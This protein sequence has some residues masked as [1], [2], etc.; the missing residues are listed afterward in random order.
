MSETQLTVWLI[1]HAKSSWAD[2]GT[3]D[4]DRPLNARGERDGPSMSAWL[5][6]QP[7]RAS[8]LMT[9]PARRALATSRFVADG[10]ELAA[11]R[12][13]E[14]AELYDATPETILDT[15]RTTPPDV[16]SVAVVAHNPGMTETTNLLCGERITEN[17]P[18]FGTA[19]LRVPAPWAT[20]QFGQAVLQ[21][22][23]SPKLL[24]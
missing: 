16:Q 19:C 9:S 17:L 20:L 13:D 5:R 15:I 4:F 2:P 14:R 7:Q 18:T 8:W 1:R 24:P 21:Q 22:L 12:V 6:G 23:I 11:A 3:R 10:F